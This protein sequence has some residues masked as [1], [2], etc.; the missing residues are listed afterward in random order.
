MF[1]NFFRDYPELLEEVM[2]EISIFQGQKVRYIARS[3]KELSPKIAEQSSY[4]ERVILIPSGKWYVNVKLDNQQKRQ[5]LS[6]IAKR[7]DLVEGRDCSWHNDSPKDRAVK[8]LRAA[9]REAVARV[10]L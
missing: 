1:T 3:P 5:I 7:V 9:G 8:G 2:K 10:E 6:N 4:Y